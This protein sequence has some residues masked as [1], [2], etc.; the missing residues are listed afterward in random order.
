VLDVAEAS[1]TVTTAPAEVRAALRRIRIY[2][3]PIGEPRFRRATDVVLLVPALVALSILIATYPPGPFG[4]SLAA[5]LNAVPGFTQPVWL[6][7]YDLLATWTIALLV[8]AVVSRRG[9]VLGQAAVA[10]A[11]AVA[12]AFVSARLAAGTWP[13][14]AD[15]VRRGAEA[16]SFPDLRIAQT[17]A[18]LLTISPRLVRPLQ[19]ACRWILVLGFL[20]A[21]F[22]DS[23]APSGV[24]AG[25]LIGVVAAAVVRLAFGTSVGRPGLDAVAAALAELGIEA[26]RPELA[27]RQVAGVVSVRALDS[28]GH[29]LLVEV[30]GRDAADNQ[31]LE[32]LWR[33]LWYQDGGPSLRLSSAQVAEHEAFVTLLAQSGGVPTYQVLRAATTTGGNALLVLRGDAR[34][35]DWLDADGADDNVLAGS[36]RAL[37]LLH[38]ARI[39][40]RRIDTHTVALLSGEV[41]LIDFAG[42]TAGPTAA[43]LLTDRA[44]LLVTTAAVAGTDRAITA[45]VSSLGEDGVAELVPYLQPAALRGSLRQATK[46]AGIDLDELRNEAA[47]RVGTEE[48]GLVRL[49]RVTWGSLIQAALLLLA[50]LAVL[51]F[52]TGIDY[53]QLWESLQDAS[54]GWILLGFVVAQLPRLTQATA[55][56]GSVAADL[57]FGP[58]YAMQ[59]ATSYMNLALPSSAARLAVNIRF[60]QR[61]GITP[62][63]AVTAGAI[64]SFASTVLQAVLLA[65]LLIFTEANLNLEFSAPSGGSLAVVA[66]LAGLVVAAVAVAVLVGRL[67]R[68]L[69][70]WV[71]RFWPEVRAALSALRSSNKIALLFGGSLATELLFAFALGLFALGLGTRISFADV[72]VLNIGVSLITTIVPIPGGIGVSELGLTVGLASAGMTEEAALA[73]VLLYRISTFYLPPT[74]GFFALRYL[75]RNRYL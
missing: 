58:V 14:L 48:P 64:D 66:V 18:V 30:Y 17:T 27:A 45:A 60:F 73:A 44:Q 19:R 41:G 5:F 51:S 22:V 49:R 11:L 16:P 35:L 2:S 33:T 10:F 59:L 70:G 25:L 71:R 74:W 29:P 56:L 1:T 6:F 54:W 72:L 67:R 21:F 47:S 69:V 38:R 65:L 42:A 4:R 23:T 37:D 34:P 68:L 57:R 62:A 9:F 39:A 36:W 46:A 43:Q 8:T 53:D 7:L 28:D 3:S 32:K 75:Q 12:V 55:T 15:L 50:A 20:G 26:G 52:A 24:A 31:L 63:G 13:E 61:Q 40:H